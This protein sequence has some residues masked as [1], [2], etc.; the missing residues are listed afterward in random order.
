MKDFPMFLTDYGAASLIL[1]EIP[2]RQEAYIHVHDTLQPEELIR[3]CASFCTAC[4]AERV[5]ATG[6][7]WLE[8]LPLHTAVLEMRGTAA[9]EEDK[10]EH[11]WPVTSENVPDFISLY[12]T[13]MGHVDNAATMTEKNRPELLE[14]GS[15]FV[16]HR[17]ELLGA[18]I[19]HEERLEFIAAV[20]RGQGDRVLASLLT[21]CPGEMVRLEVASTNE[22]AIRL[23]E[24]NGFFVTRE[25]SRWYRV[26]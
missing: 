10:T 22:K 12:N 25:L 13:A 11:L 14:C 24:R 23:Y 6:H 7:S 20:K 18:G 9:P 17:G 8:G 15:Y 16:H 26:K 2:Y 1:R 3:E 21:L 4:G 5:Y 19:L